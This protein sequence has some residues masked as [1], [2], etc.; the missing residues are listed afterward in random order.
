MESLDLHI[1]TIQRRIVE[2][3]DQLR[4]FCRDKGGGLARGLRPAR[5]RRHSPHRN[6]LRARS[7]GSGRAS[8]PAD[9]PYK[10]CHGGLGHGADHLLPAIVS[11]LITIPIEGGNPTRGQWQSLILVDFNADKPR[12]RVRL[13]FLAG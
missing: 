10:H 5:H 6:R 2:L 12:R 4:G 9:L 3:V 7:R 13:N 11:P 1:D 8:G